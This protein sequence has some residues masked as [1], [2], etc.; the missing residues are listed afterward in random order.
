MDKD[1]IC[2]LLV[3]APIIATIG[4]LYKCAIW[5]M[6][7]E[8]D[9]ANT[10]DIYKYCKYVNSIEEKRNNYQKYRE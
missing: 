7:K 6:T 8:V 3:I 1:I 5:N 10:D 2:L 9:R 4:A